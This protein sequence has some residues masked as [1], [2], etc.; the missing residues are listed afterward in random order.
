VF[1]IVGDDLAR[2]PGYLTPFAD[3]GLDLSGTDFQAIAEWYR[4]T[5]VGDGRNSF[6]RSSFATGAGWRAQ[7]ILDPARSDTSVC[8]SGETPLDC[9]LRLIQPSVAIVSVGYN[10][11]FSNTD[12]N[13]FQSSMEQII[14]SLLR[15][16]VIPIVTTVQPIPGM[17]AQTNAINNAI[18]QAAR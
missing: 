4:M 2:Q 6:G 17:E 5:D 12:P 11:V 3:P 16:G 14:Q 7:D 9:E 10:D 8:S 15:Q 18:I 13:A 1:A